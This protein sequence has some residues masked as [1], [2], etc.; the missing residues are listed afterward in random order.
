[1]SERGTVNN[2]TRIIGTG[3][4]RSGLMVTLLKY[5]PAPS[6]HYTETL[7]SRLGNRLRILFVNLIIYNFIFSMFPSLGVRL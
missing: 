4:G 5:C 6:S 7:R 2:Y 1:M 3:P